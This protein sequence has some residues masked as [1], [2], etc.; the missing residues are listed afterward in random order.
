MGFYDEL[1]KSPPRKKTLIER[2]EADYPKVLQYLYEDLLRNCAYQKKLGR[3]EYT[4][5]SRIG[6]DV[7]S[8]YVGMSWIEGSPEVVLK[9]FQSGWGWKISAA[10]KDAPGHIPR[11]RASL[12]RYLAESAFLDRSRSLRDRLLWDLRR[13]LA[14]EN[15]PSDCLTPVDLPI[16][17]ETSYSFLTGKPTGYAHV[18]DCYYVMVSV[19]W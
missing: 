7:E 17:V 15:F 19:R 4:A 10:K 5:Y 8:D 6:H 13:K 3:R 11:D 9:D 12:G 18:F 16:R 14:A 1:K 2:V